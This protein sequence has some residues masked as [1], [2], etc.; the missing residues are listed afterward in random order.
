MTWGRFRE[1]EVNE[2]KIGAHVPLSEHTFGCNLIFILVHSVRH[3]MKN[4]E[5]D[6]RDPAVTELTVQWEV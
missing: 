3:R 5:R 1:T 4:S 6:R 2:V